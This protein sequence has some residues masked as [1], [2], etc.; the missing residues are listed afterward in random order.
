VAQTIPPI[1]IPPAAQASFERLLA[2][3]VPSQ[4]ELLHALEG[5]ARVLELALAGQRSIVFVHEITDRC[6]AM[7][8][9]WNALGPEARRLVAAAVR[10]FALRD[11]AVDDIGSDFGLVDDAQVVNAVLAHFGFALPPIEIPVMPASGPRDVD[12]GT[13]TSRG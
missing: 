9:R 12:P 7:L 5:H 10:Y 4:H 8:E 2:G 11:D 13:D 3:P 6:R 1:G